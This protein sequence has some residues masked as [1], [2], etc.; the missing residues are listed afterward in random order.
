MWRD[1]MS[2]HT[3]G[4]EKALSQVNEFLQLLDEAQV[5]TDEEERERLYERLYDHLYEHLGVEEDDEH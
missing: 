4:K 3:P 1:D 5:A 2:D